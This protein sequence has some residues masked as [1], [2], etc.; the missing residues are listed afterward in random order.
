[1]VLTEEQSED[2]KKAILAY[3]KESMYTESFKQ[4]QEEVKLKPT[5][6]KN[7]MAVKWRSIAKLNKQI[8]DLEAKVKALEEDN[9]DPNKRP[10]AERLPRAPQKFTMVGHKDGITCVKFHPNYPVIASSAEDALIKIWDADTGL[11]ERT[12]AGHQDAVQCIAF[13]PKGIA[14]ASCSAD[15]MIKVWDTEE[16][17]CI[18]TLQGHDHNISGITYSRDGSQLISCSRDK[19]IRVWDAATGV[20]RETLSGHTEWVRQV[21]VSPNGRLLASCSVDLTIKIWDLITY[22]CIKTF[23][24]HEHYVE[25]IA[26]SSSVNADNVIIDNILSPEEKQRTR[27]S[28]AKRKEE[29]GP[30]YKEEWGRFVVSGSRDRTIRLWDTA[31][32]SNAALLTLQGHTNWVRSLVFHPGG[33]FI[34]SASDDKSIRVWD[35]SQK[36]LEVRKLEAAHD[37]FVTSIDI[38][39]HLPMLCSG[40]VEKNVKVWELFLLF[41]LLVLL[42]IIFLMLH[43]NQKI[44]QIVVNVSNVVLYHL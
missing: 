12:M 7:Y 39:H 13:H 3:L 36:G 20:C 37:L 33:Q 30:N 6:K 11:E 42:L 25:T 14:I 17:K 34:I 44:I 29:D 18:K 43:L 24:D 23:K 32:S 22:E 10:A 35:L 19:T 40:G 5:S 26:F 38:S 9:S 4:L 21:V 2:L 8:V 41:V 16:Y 28:Q 31:G 27:E 15:M 1:M